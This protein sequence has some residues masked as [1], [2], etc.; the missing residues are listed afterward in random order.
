MW[1]KPCWA[2]STVS[3]DSDSATTFSVSAESALLLPEPGPAGGEGKR[4][5]NFKDEL[6][7]AINKG[8]LFVNVGASQRETG[9]QVLDLAPNLSRFLFLGHP[10][11][12][13]CSPALYKLC[14]MRSLLINFSFAIPIHFFSFAFWFFCLDVFLLL[15]ISEGGI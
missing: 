6:A 10:S 5:R 2:H 1:G 11:L 12:H 15:L 13:R 8:S 14:E 3:L 9:Y 4:G 7:V